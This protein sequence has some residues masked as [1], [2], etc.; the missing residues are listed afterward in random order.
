MEA[1]LMALFKN[2]MFIYLSQLWEGKKIEKFFLGRVLKIKKLELW[3]WRISL[4]YAWPKGLSALNHLQDASPGS[5][6]ALMC[7]CDAAGP[8]SIPGRDKF[9]GWGFFFGVFRHLSDKCLE[10]SGPR[11]SFGHHYHHSSSFITGDNDLRCWRALKP[12][13]YILTCLVYCINHTLW[14]SWSFMEGER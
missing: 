1:T 12:Q 6:P 3:H 4:G 13:I 8:G 10:T 14:K 11:I 7:S 2:E 5:W 9:P